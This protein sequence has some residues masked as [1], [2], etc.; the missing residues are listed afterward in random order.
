[1]KKTIIWIV[2]ALV[3]AGLM[4]GVY[5]LYN[6][7]SKEYENEIPQLPNLPTN[8]DTNVSGGKETGENDS[9]DEYSGSETEPDQN[10]PESEADVSTDA[11]AP[12]GDGDVIDSEPETEA[13]SVVFNAPDFTFYDKNGNEVK[14]SDFAGKPIVLN[15]WATWCYYCKVEMPDFN[16]MYKKYPD[17]EF[18]MLNATTTNGETQAGAEK[19]INDNG[20]EFP[21]YFDLDGAGL[22]AYHV[23]GF[24]TTV[25]ITRSG[26]LVYNQG[27]MLNATQLEGV[28]KQLIQYN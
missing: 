22:N 18:I 25:L 14:L 4:I 21:V 11:D 10:T 12:S 8:N 27:G 1:M 9:F 2:V 3:C 26:E 17:V 16:E 5:A 28:I 13:P 7:L 19:Y 6:N 24:P 23:T 15:I 20:F